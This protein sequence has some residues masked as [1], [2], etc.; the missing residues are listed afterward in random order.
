MDQAV[1]AGN[2]PGLVV[3]ARWGEP[4]R[5]YDIIHAIDLGYLGHGLPFELRNAIAVQ[6]I[7]CAT[8]G[9]RDDVL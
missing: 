5:L 1:P 9:D 7:H 2:E 4:C 8:E 6:L 3:H